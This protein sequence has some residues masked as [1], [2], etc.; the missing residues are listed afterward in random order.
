LSYEETAA[1]SG[2]TAQLILGNTAQHSVNPHYNT[3]D[4]AETKRIK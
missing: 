2:I 3:Y 4:F 1:F